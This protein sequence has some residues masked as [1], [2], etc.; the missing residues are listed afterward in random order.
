[1]SARVSS[2]S[3]ESSR[4]SH[5]VEREGPPR[6]GDVVL[7][8]RR[9]ARLLVGRDD[10]PLQE[11][12]VDLAADEHRDVERGAANRASGDA[13]VS[14][15]GDG[16]ARARQR[17]HRQ[18]QRGGHARLHVGVARALDDA[19]RRGRGTARARSRR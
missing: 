1:M 8:V 7:D 6:G 3:P 18:R 14:G 10:E 13:A 9:L 16:Q 11:A 17:R 2:A 15:R 12:G 4:S 5:R 19:G